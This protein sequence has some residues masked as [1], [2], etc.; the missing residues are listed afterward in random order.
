VSKGGSPPESRAAGPKTAAPGVTLALV[1]LLALGGVS[2]SIRRMAVNRLGDA[3]ASGSSAYSGD[4]DPE[5]VRDAVPFGLKTIEGLL[6]ESPRHQG[7]LLAATSGFT[8]YAYAYLQDEA[9]YVEDTDLARAT[10]LRRRAV[11]M[12]RRA[13]GYGLRGLEVRSPGIGAGLRRDPRGVVAGLGAH[14]V[15][16]MYWTAAAWGSAISAAKQDAELAAD[17]PAVEAL[18]RRCLQLD[19]KFGDGA[20]YDFLISYEGG[21]PASAG[22]SVAR[23]REALDKALA[24]SQGKRAAPLVSFAETVDV[25]EQNRSEFEALLKKA[26]AVDPDA[27]PDQ[28]L[29]NR[30][31]QRRARWLLSRADQLFVE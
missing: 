8:Q 22:G 13:L 9:D 3:L 11:A 16:L 10:E 5:F 21:R 23:A 7:L 15:P 29:A 20:I 6:A 14:E 28:R 27:V 24:I 18:M 26:L 17:L 12:Y 25:G 1:A 19:E 4:D 2:C 31:A 30:I